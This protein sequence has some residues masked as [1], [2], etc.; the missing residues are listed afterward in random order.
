MFRKLANSLNRWPP[1]HIDGL[2]DLRQYESA[3]LER[4][5][6]TPNG[7]VLFSLNPLML[8]KD[9]GVR[10]TSE[11]ESD[12]K[13]AAPRLDRLDTEI[14]REIRSNKMAPHV[15]VKVSRLFPFIRND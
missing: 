13:R 8:F 6:N 12:L 10:L 15:S 3:I 1:I 11:A 4:I 9:L 5:N 14:Y 7:G 2:D